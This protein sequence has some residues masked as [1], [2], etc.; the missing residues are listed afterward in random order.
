MKFNIKSIVFLVIL[1][2]T[3]QLLISQ[4]LSY[5]A[6]YFG[7]FHNQEYF[8][9]Y[10]IPQTMGGSRI[11]GQ[12]GVQMNENQSFYA[13]ANYLYE[14]GSDPGDQQISPTLY[15]Q[16]QHK[17][18]DVFLGSFP[19]Y[20]IIDMPLILVTDSMLYYHPNIEGI[21]LRG[22]SEWGYHNAWLDWTS[23]QTDTRNEEFTLGLSGQFNIGNFF[24]RHHFVMCHYAGKAIR[25]EVEHIRDNGG[26]L[27]GLGID[28]SSNSIFDT[29]TLYTAWALSYDQH[30]GI[31][32]TRFYNGF[33]AEFNILYKFIGI[34]NIFYSGE[35]QLQ[36]IGDKFFT[37]KTYNRTDIYWKLFKQKW[38]KGYVEFG[39]HIVPGA[40][41]WHQKFTVK[42][43]MSGL[44]KIKGYEN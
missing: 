17:K 33:Y 43:D 15:Y 9:E 4:D 11:Y 18:L 22:K 44:R 30:R 38:V 23:R 39:F 26:G 21:Y 42:I 12:L 8:N 31:Y 7:F 10:I 20:D 27:V 2:G 1:V 25:E 5:K 35:G 37:A 13:G 40:F 3:S 41:D 6:G 32:D 34:S 29:L 16:F 36:T 24:Y 19:R 14:F 28:L